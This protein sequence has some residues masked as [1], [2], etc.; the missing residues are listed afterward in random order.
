MPLP[1]RSSTRRRGTT[2]ALLA[3]LAVAG[4]GAPARLQP[5]PS[6]PVCAAFERYG[7]LSGTTITVAEPA[8]GAESG[9]ERGADSERRIGGYD[10]FTRCAG[11]RIEHRDALGP[12]GLLQPGEP[13]PDLGYLPDAAALTDLVRRTGAVRPAP[14]PV[15]ANVAEFY[16]ETYR[17]AGSV[18]GTLYAAPLDATVKSLVWYS[19][20]VFTERGYRVPTSWDDLLALSGRIVSDG[21]TPWCAGTTAAAATGASLV[22]DL[23]HALLRSAGPETFDAWVGHAIPVDSPQ[24]VAALAEVGAL[25]PDPAAVG[26]G[27]PAGGVTTPVPGGGVLPPSGGCLLRRADDRYPATLPTGA[28]AAAD[29]E[30]FAFPMPPRDPATGPVAV[31]GGGFVVAFT[32][33]RE[34]QALHAY[35]S[36]PDWAAAMARTAGPGWVSP[37]GGLDP[38]APGEPVQ[39]LVLGLLQD[40][41]ATLRYDGSDRMPPAVGSGALPQ[42]LTSWFTGAT[43]TGDALAS[44]EA[45]WPR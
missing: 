36:T 27:A 35:L 2:A 20:R 7:D 26:G 44:V 4:C 30:L 39:R 16:P 40:P 29:G 14:P 11:A 19:P 38:A 43:G 32:D 8:S 17:A 1:R 9:T 15:A 34:V 10:T 3:V 25:R 23:E 5:A 45:A 13:P 42:A 21:G 18:D 6:D 24:V 31:V 28:Q 41:R 37:N 12:T 22:D 33:R